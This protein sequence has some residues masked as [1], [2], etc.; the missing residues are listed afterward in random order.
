MHT[1]P[2]SII[3][4]WVCSFDLQISSLKY[5]PKLDKN[6]VSIIGS[7][8]WHAKPTLWNIDAPGELERLQNHDSEFLRILFF[9]LSCSRYLPLLS[10]LCRFFEICSS[11]ARSTSCAFLLVSSLNLRFFSCKQ[12]TRSKCII[13]KYD[14]A[15]FDPLEY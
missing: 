2:P 9:A 5:I 15:K 4:Y 6:K 1:T 13:K 14:K 11:F 8:K 3:P 7:R 12:R 10:S